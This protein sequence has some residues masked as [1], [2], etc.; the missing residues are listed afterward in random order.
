MTWLCP[1]ALI[2]NMVSYRLKDIA[3]ENNSHVIA[4]M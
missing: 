4:T 1:Y 2:Q 3:Y